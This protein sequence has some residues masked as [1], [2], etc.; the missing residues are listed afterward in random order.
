MR[1][2]SLTVG[3]LALSAPFFTA[4]AQADPGSTIS[5]AVMR[6]GEQI[7]TNTIQLHRNGAETTVQIVTHVAV[8]IAFVTV[9]RFDQTETERWVDGRLAALRSSTDD[10]GTVHRVKASGGDNKI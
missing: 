2:R 1:L 7:G 3:I 10:N 6:N 8:K 4:A 9:Y 5:F